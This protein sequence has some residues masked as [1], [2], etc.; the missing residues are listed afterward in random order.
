MSRLVSR[1]FIWGFTFF[2]AGLLF[3][4]VAYLF[5]SPKLPDAESLRTVQ[6]QIPLRIFSEEGLL[7]AEFGEKRRIPVTYENIPPKLIEAF[8]AAEDD[9]FFE[10]PGVDYQGLIRAAYSLALTGEKAQGGS[11]ITMQVARNFFLSNEK[12]YL[13]KI[14][15][16]ILSLEIENT[17]TKEEILALYLNKI[18]LGH[19][20]YGVGAA[21][22]V[23][24]GKKLEDLTLAQ[25]ATIA[26]LPKAPSTTNPITSPER[27]LDRR[28]YVLR[29]MLDVGYISQ[30]EYQEAVKEEVSAR[31]HGREIEVYAPYVAEMVRTYLVAEYGEESYEK[32]LR[33]YTTIKAK[34]QQ[35][36]TKALQDAL[37]AYDKRHG[38]R[39]PAAKVD[40]S[41]LPDLAASELHLKDFAIIGSISPALVLSI[42]NNTAQVFVKRHGQIELPFT[43]VDWAQP[44]LSANSMG[45]KPQTISDVLAVGDIIYLRALEEDAWQLTQIPEAQAAFVSLAPED[46]AITSLQGGFDFFQNKFNRVTQSKRQ[47][48]SGFKPFVYSAALEKGYTAATVVNDAP[49]VFDDPGL[50]NVWRPEN[51]SGRFFGPTRLREALTHS[52]NLVSIRLLR[53]IGIPYTVDYVQ[54]FG[55]KPEQVPPNLSIALGSGNAAPLDM[56]RAYATLANGGHLIDPY[57]ISRVENTAGEIL[58]QTKPKKVCDSCAMA[59]LEM[60]EEEAIMQSE[61]L[62]F[63]PAPQVIT[64]QNAYIVNSMLRDVV[65]YGTGRQALSLNRNDLAGK[66]GTTNDQL[67]AWF[68]GY[69]PD[70][71]GIGW[72][73]F[74]NPRTLGRY[75]TGGRAALPM[76]IDFMRVALEDQPEKD[77]IQPVDMVTVR[78]DPETGL[79]ARPGDTNAIYETFHKDNVP[80]MRGG[81]GPGATQNQDD[82]LIELF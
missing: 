25:M 54:R 1:L 64:P 66:T 80:T 30:S 46:G 55:F 58:M 67:D 2:I 48:G 38:Y 18:F 50:E 61:L 8:L 28:N 31:Y 12:T 5:L 19:R 49:V 29:R 79:L 78:I 15:E 35:A 47:P 27:A 44:Q 37:L 68:N 56:A 23:Y 75:E 52:R 3:V 63:T 33:V 71:V 77:F 70:L 60:S 73:G 76:W 36:A 10:H 41:E 7:M 14:N 43:A 17:L 40:L 21:A 4:A 42:E 45:K 24:Y 13:R 39:G 81:S 72:V 20:S 53:D 69:T 16:I 11:T 34:H 57:V 65:K 32:G 6:L 62:G 9:R 74:D 51:Y 22:E 26:G 82:S 59:A